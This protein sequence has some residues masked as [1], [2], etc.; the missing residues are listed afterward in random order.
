MPFLTTSQNVT[1]GLSL[2]SHFGF[3][4]IVWYFPIE[5]NFKLISAYHQLASGD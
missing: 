3:G 5:N 2:G 1:E 4:K